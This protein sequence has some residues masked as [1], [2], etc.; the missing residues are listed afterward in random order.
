MTVEERID[1]LERDLN[2]LGNLHNELQQQFVEL[3]ELSVKLARNNQ[4]QFKIVWDQIKD[5]TKLC[6]HNR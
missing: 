3:I 2:H 4:E 5:L 6:T 1:A